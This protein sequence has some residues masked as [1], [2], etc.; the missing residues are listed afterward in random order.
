MHCSL[1]LIKYMYLTITIANIINPCVHN[2]CI[3][4][5]RNELC[6]YKRA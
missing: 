1:A 5:P 2:K 6:Y 4:V 3:Q